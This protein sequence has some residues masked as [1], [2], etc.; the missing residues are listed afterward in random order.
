MG[1]ENDTGAHTI[2]F[3][4]TR[5]EDERSLAAFL[6]L[7]SRDRLTDILIPRMTDA[8]IE[9]TVHLLTSIMRNHLSEKEYH[10][11]FLGNGAQ[12]H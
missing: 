11:L 9:Q 1:H 3:G 5:A 6:K 7:F 12:G 2:L 8:E 4:L 10:T